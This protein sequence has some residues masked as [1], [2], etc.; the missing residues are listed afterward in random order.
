M[1]ILR[2][3]VFTL[4]LDEA[5]DLSGE[6]ENTEIKGCNA[7]TNLRFVFDGKTTADADVVLTC[8]GVCC[9]SDADE[10]YDWRRKRREIDKVKRASGK[11]VFLFS[12]IGLCAALVQNEL[13]YIDTHPKDPK[14][15]V[16]PSSCMS[17]PCSPV[18][19]PHRSIS[20]MPLRNLDCYQNANRPP[21]APRNTP[22]SSQQV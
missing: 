2:L 15:G 20:Q 11:W 9:N 19:P 16:A 13:I 17:L 12:M 6:L 3:Q 18:F 4:D 7:G 8:V 22:S 5:Q 10:P 14:I 21:S 1:C